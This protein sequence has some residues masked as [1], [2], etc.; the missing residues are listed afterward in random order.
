MPRKRKKWRK[1]ESE[2]RLCC[3]LQKTGPRFQPQASEVLEV[4]GS[5]ISLYLSSVFALDAK[6]REKDRLKVDGSIMLPFCTK[7]AQ[8]PILGPPKSRSS[9]VT[10][11]RHIYLLRLSLIRGGGPA[12]SAASKN[13]AQGPYLWPPKFWSSGILQFF[14][15]FSHDV[16]N[17]K[18]KEAG[19]RCRSI[20]NF[21]ISKKKAQV[22]HLGPPKFR[23]SVVPEFRCILFVRLC[24]IPETRRQ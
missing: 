24:L 6:K 17:T 5:Q 20:D 13:L 10:E 22:P 2:A 9:L 7:I 11:F 15:A 3:H 8:G 12:N 21:A 16:G 1:L 14:R 18:K 4:R 19:T 23:S